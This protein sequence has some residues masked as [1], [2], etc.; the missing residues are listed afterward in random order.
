MRG[1][2]FRVIGAD[3]VE[4]MLKDYMVPKLPRRLQV[5]TKAGATVFK[6]P[7]K[8]AARP[9]SKRLAR[10][11]SVRVAKRDKPASVV[12][13]RPKVAFFRHFIIGGTA[14]H[15]PRRARA[16]VFVGNGGLIRTKRVRGT[17][18]HPIIER[19]FESNKSK[20]DQAINHALDQSESR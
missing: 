9:L 7:L 15:G 5:A 2:T 16:L 14:D 8:S 4:T 19:V 13:F 10:S 12:T 18:P 3:G 11:V 1:S 17:P 6:E 20:A